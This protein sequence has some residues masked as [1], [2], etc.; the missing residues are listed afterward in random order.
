MHGAS[1][2]DLWKAYIAG[3]KRAG[4]NA[5]KNVYVAS[6]LLTYN[7]LE[8]MSGAKNKNEL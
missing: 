1:V 8:G 5:N 7:D 4:F 6:G 2:Q 3:M